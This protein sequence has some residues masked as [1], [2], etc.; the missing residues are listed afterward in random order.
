MDAYV[1]QLRL[2]HDPFADAFQRDDFYGGGNRDNLVYTVL[3][4]ERP[5]VSLDAVIGPSGS[6]KTRLAHRLCECA[7]IHELPVLVVVDLFTTEAQLLGA[8]L[9]ELR[10]SPPREPG[11][12]LNSLSEH[13]INLNRDG[14]SILLL[15]DNAHELGPGCLRLVERLL[16]NRWS[17]LH[18]VLLGED[19]LADMLQTR[20]RE[21]HRAGLAIHELKPLNRVEIADYIHLKL[22]SAGHDRKLSMTSQAALDILQQCGGLPG[23]INA[24]TAAMLARQ[25]RGSAT[26]SPRERPPARDAETA[27]ARQVERP[28]IRYLWQALALSIV[29]AVVVFWP[30][31]A[32][33]SSASPPPAQARRIALPTSAGPPPDAALAAANRTRARDAAEEDEFPSLS[34]F[35]LLLLDTPADHFTVQ[36]V[37]ASSEEGVLEF[38]ATAQLGGI[39]GYYET[40][41]GRNPWFVV[42]DGVYPDWEAAMEARTRLARSFG[43][44]EPWIRRVSNVHAEIARSGKRGGS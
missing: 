13:T 44:N 38:I 17:A 37:G 31:E 15:I 35:E 22:A 33:E 28:E 9:G 40:R 5:A 1:Q 4:R 19:Q 6:G 36:L 29:L 11:G 23:K 43:E 18:L 39:H 27:P 7:P 30:V 25:A 41:Q 32:P 8:I 10:I 24:L 14:K 21:R 26:R 2:Q 12:G 20:L 3:D 16:A 42:V 34:R